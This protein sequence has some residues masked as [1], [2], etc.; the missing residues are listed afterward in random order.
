MK[1][2]LLIISLISMTICGNEIR[3]MV[4]Q[5]ASQIGEMEKRL[6]KA[7]TGIKSKFHPVVS[8]G[9]EYYAQRLAI[10]Y[11]PGIMDDYFEEFLRDII[12]TYIQDADYEQKKKISK[13]LSLSEFSAFNKIL[14][15]KVLFKKASSS[16]KMSFIAIMSEKNYDSTDFLFLVMNSNIELAN[17][18]YIKTKSHRVLFWG[19]SEEYLD[20]RP[21][22]LT[23]DDLEYLFNFLQISIFTRAKAILNALHS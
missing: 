18:Y 9:Y 20:V 7:P 22:Y 19:S 3:K 8:K 2:F 13:L 23:R 12:P 10:I 4:N 5:I 6:K 17:E 11:N 1:K 16:N 14:V 15:P 21:R